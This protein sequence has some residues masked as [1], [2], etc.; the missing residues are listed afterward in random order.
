MIAR[1]MPLRSDNRFSQLVAMCVRLAAADG[2]ATSIADLFIY[3]L[4]HATWLESEL[5]PA[6][7]IA[8]RIRTVLPAGQGS[9]GGDRIAFDS[10]AC[11]ND[12]ARF[13]MTGTPTLSRFGCYQHA[14]L[15]WLMTTHDRDK[16]H[17]KCK[18]LMTDGTLT[19]A[20]ILTAG[21]SR[22]G[23][24]VDEDWLALIRT[25][26]HEIVGRADQLKRHRQWVATAVGNRRSYMVTGAQGVGKSLFLDHLLL[27]C[28]EQRARIHSDLSD[29]HRFVLI[30]PAIS[31]I[32]SGTVDTE[33][34]RLNTL[35]MKIPSIVPVFDEFDAFMADDTFRDAFVEFFGSLLSHGGRT[36]L[37]A[38]RPMPP[39][40]QFA[41][42]DLERRQIPEIAFRDV[43]TA[44]RQFLVSDFAARGIKL[45][46]E[47]EPQRF[48]REAAR[49]AN[50]YLSSQAQ[51]KCTLDLI[52]KV[53]EFVVE[54][55]GRAAAIATGVSLQDLLTVVS[56]EAGVEES[57]LST[58][59]ATFY[60]KIE[61]SVAA[62]IIGQ[63]HAL[64]RICRRL[65]HWES[66]IRSVEEEAG[67]DRTADHRL[68][69]IRILLVGPPGIGKTETARSL[70][71]HLGRPLH[72][73]PMNQ[74][75]TEMGRTSLV[76]SDAGYEK[77]GQTDTIFTLVQDAPRCVI[78]LDEIEKAHLDVQNILLGIFEGEGKDY[79]GKTVSFGQVIFLMTSNYSE[80]LI[81][82][83]Y[84]ARRKQSS[85][86]QVAEV[87]TTSVV[88]SMLKQ[89]VGA[90]VEQEMLL[91]LDESR[92]RIAELFRQQ[93]KESGRK[94][95]E[96]NA[97]RDELAA[98]RA[99]TELV[100]DYLRYS[101]AEKQ[102]QGLKDGKSIGS[103]LLDRAHEIIP[104]FPFVKNTASE[105]FFEVDDAGI[106]QKLV[107]RF[108]KIGVTPEPQS[109]A[110]IEQL[111]PTL[112]SVRTIKT[113]VEQSGDRS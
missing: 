3:A 61:A 6:A 103:A 69:P 32:H 94:A 77:S 74:Y 16:T 43:V 37:F 42:R 55:D 97:T 40:Q 19:E 31:V 75:S 53:A 59:P 28:S 62:E 24:W 18:A 86:Q 9:T 48:C 51:P 87:L 71:R 54:R 81:T 22:L 110:K 46:A 50:L 68:E 14:L 107:C 78:L 84:V 80:K 15:Y 34:E 56:I 23:E 2:R 52:L 76:G 102:L 70:A 82:S 27:Q 8:N 90:E 93:R 35:M 13:L 4:K 33:L 60:A 101:A 7:G 105:E 47:L 67:D 109:V 25:N 89:G 106:V 72:V 10:T 66:R 112:A 29:R 113:I 98:R 108:L 17:A 100:E 12:F 104:Y 65:E 26:R 57:L 11:A 49:F 30:R 111:V 41:F 91:F 1:S 99:S 38:S 20:A 83:E 85:R 63:E 73:F 36:M 96:T 79:A 92:Q 45:A 88:K 5:K 39:A 64:D 95:T 58:D 44:A 21:P